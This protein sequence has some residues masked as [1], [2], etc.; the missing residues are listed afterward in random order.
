MSEPTADYADANGRILDLPA[1][2][3]LGEGG[4]VDGTNYFLLV[5]M[6][7]SAADYADSNW[8]TR[9]DLHITARQRLAKRMAIEKRVIDQADRWRVFAQISS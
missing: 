4:F 8:R 5:G 9:K 7:E 6:V 2:H 3:S 1:S